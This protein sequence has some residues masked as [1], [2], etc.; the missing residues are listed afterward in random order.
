MKNVMLCGYYGEMNTGDDALLAVASWGV[1][2]FL[3]GPE[4]VVTA[5]R[6][7]QIN[8]EKLIKPIF[9]SQR[10]LRGEKLL[11]WYWHARRAQSI[12]SGG[13]STFHSSLYMRLLTSLITVAGPGPHGA[14]GI[15]IGPFRDA[16]ADKVCAR[17]L[18]RLDFVG[19][20]DQSSLEIA[21][22]IAPNAQVRKTFDLAPLLPRASGSSIEGLQAGTDRKGT[23]FALCNWERFNGRDGSHEEVRLRNVA[24]AINALDPEITGEIIL[25]DFNGSPRF[26]DYGLNSEL[27][28]NISPKFKVRHVIYDSNPMQVLEQIAQLKVL[29]SMRL[30]GSV[31]GY[32]ANTPTLVISYHP[33]CTGWAGQIG[34]DKHY[35]IDSNDIDPGELTVKINELL[36]IKKRTCSLDPVEAEKLA[37]DNWTWLNNTISP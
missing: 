33:K 23:G 7:P 10:R 20:R 9:T 3:H 14:M 34:L 28:K 32:I 21:R 36:T 29:V 19:V 31:F 18:E 25:I 27:K 30:H 24:A 5:P 11:R 2:N 1:H 13:G 35:V 26:G 8:N 15:S 17:L 12:F 16:G 37:L 22:A 4:I 6:I